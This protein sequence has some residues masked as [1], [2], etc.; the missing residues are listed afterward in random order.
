MESI[1]KALQELR[2]L[3]YKPS[4]TP[5]ED[6]EI[7]AEIQIL[8]GLRKA[9]EHNAREIKVGVSPYGGYFS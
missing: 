6:K 8:E 4:V 9:M 2:V 7:R 3:L 1:N 5:Q